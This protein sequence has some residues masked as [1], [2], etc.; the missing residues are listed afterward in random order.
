MF[1]VNYSVT[2]RSLTLIGGKRS[3][4]EVGAPTIAS[5]AWCRE[6]LGTKLSLHI[7]YACRPNQE[8]PLGP[9]PHPAVRQAI[10]YQT[11]PLI[12]QA[13]IL[14]SRDEIV[15]E[16]FLLMRNIPRVERPTFP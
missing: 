13:S 12:H 9:E 11:G 7:R 8:L 15:E 3:V 2:G 6:Y 10:L 4:S 14:G 1:S 5:R 16:I